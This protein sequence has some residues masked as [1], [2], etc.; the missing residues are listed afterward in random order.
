MTIGLGAQTRSIGRFPP[1][2]LP[3]P[4]MACIGGSTWTHTSHRKSSQGVITGCHLVCLLALPKRL[5]ALRSA[6]WV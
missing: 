5:L 3:L 6:H 1:I 4:K 2:S